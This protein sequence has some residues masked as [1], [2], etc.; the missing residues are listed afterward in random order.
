MQRNKA[1]INLWDG[2][3]QFP[4]RQAS[5]SHSLLVVDMI[6]EGGNRIMDYDDCSRL[7]QCD[8]ASC[9]KIFDQFS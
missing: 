7:S 8:Q 3:Y 4:Q 1:I 6:V 9:G 2:V 5:F